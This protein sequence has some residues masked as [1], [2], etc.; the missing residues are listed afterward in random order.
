MDPENRLRKKSAIP[1][2]G[3]GRV[4]CLRRGNEIS[5]WCRFRLARRQNAQLYFA[6]VGAD[7][8]FKHLRFGRIE[9]PIPGACG[10]VT[11]RRVSEREFT[12]G[13]LKFDRFFVGQFATKDADV[14]W[15]ADPDADSIAFNS[16]HRQGDVVANHDLLVGFP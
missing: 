11:F 2:A 3:D 8:P 4:N 7:G 12:L 1:F 10:R 5:Q 16:N 13:E 9:E 15:C 14:A 6:S